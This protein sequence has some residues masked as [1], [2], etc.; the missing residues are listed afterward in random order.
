MASARRRYITVAT[1]RPETILGDTGV[2]VNPD[3]ERYR[4]LVAAMPSCPSWT[5]DTH[6]RR[7]RRGSR[8]LARARSR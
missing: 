6:R 2:A 4:D 5:G 3:D 8:S 1:T 7:C